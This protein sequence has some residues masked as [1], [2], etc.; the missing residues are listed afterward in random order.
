MV[1]SSAVSCDVSVLTLSQFK[2]YGFGVYAVPGVPNMRFPKCFPDFPQLF[3][4]RTNGRLMD[5]WHK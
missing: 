3:C 4:R 2:K 1:G 5:K